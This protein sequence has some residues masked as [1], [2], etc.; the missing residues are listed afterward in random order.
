MI[1][2]IVESR[3]RSLFDAINRGDFEPVLNGFSRRF[4]HA[5]VGTH[6]LGG[7]RHSLASTRLWY[8]RLYRLLP[9]IHFAVDRIS[10]RGWPWSMLAI[11]E[12]RESNSGTDG[13]V[14]TARGVHVV[15]IKWGKMTRLLIVPE[16]HALLGTLDRLRATGV[17][18]AGAPPIVD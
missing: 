7:E 11:A 1:H 8:E 18:E 13:V 17:E 6:A 15:W 9:D 5:F 10:V 3:I 12:W 2:R 14:T 4:E 16:T